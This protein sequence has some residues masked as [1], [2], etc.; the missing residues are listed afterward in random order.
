[1]TI[2]ILLKKNPTYFYNIYFSDLINGWMNDIYNSEIYHCSQRTVLWTQNNSYRRHAYTHLNQDKNKN[3]NIS[4]EN[5]WGR[6]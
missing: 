5:E 3:L 2:I 6:K 1:M 4:S